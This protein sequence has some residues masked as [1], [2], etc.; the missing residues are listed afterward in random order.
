MIL[1]IVAILLFFIQIWES[2]HFAKTVRKAETKTIEA[3]VL[4]ALKAYATEYGYSLTGNPVQMFAAL[5]GNNQR[6]IIFFEVR[7]DRFNAQGEL[8]DPWDTPYRFDLSKPDAPRIWSC[9]PNRKDEGGAE[10]SDDI[11]SW[12]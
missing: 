8:I 7:S 12:R 6:K 1:G 2:L 3:G 4:T 10:G 5:R 9:G 11:V